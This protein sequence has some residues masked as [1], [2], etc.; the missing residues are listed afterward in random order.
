MTEYSQ[1]D[2][3]I[4][5]S[6][7]Q[8][9]DLVQATSRPY[10]NSSIRREVSILCKNETLLAQL[11]LSPSVCTNTSSLDV[12]TLSQQ[13]LSLLALLSAL[14][15]LNSTHKF[16]HLDKLQQE[17]ATYEKLTKELYLFVNHPFI[18]LCGPDVKRS[19]E[20]YM[21]RFLALILWPALIDQKNHTKFNSSEGNRK[22]PYVA[23]ECF[24]TMHVNTPFI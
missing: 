2:S 14:T 1:S 17:F 7:S 4:A 18:T 9:T 8:L 22:P 21:L 6:I 24:K 16:Q 5:A 23:K 19:Q 12:S 13:Q 20:K 15:Q 3:G 10:T 11:K